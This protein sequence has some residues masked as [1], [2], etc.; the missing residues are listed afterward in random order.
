MFHEN[1]EIL[2]RKLSEDIA[3]HLQQM[4][5]YNQHHHRRPWSFIRF[6]MK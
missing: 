3:R 4:R 2:L 5:E 1:T 6:F